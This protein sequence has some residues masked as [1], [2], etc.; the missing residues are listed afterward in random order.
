M[1]PREGHPKRE[2]SLVT[3]ALVELNPSFHEANADGLFMVLSGCRGVEVGERSRSYNGSTFGRWRVWFG[4]SRKDDAVKRLSRAFEGNTLD[5]RYLA[6][7]DCFNRG[8]YFEAHEVLEDLWLEDRSGQDGNFYKGLIQLA[9][10]FVH[11]QK[12]RTG[13]AK[14]LFRLA[15]SN[16]SVYPDRHH[17]VE[18]RKLTSRIQRWIDCIERG[19][20]M[21]FGPEA[22]Q[23]HSQS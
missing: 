12:G 16:L 4:M 2:S 22:L 18:T 11:V 17:A 7:F 21:P 15:L 19:N 9:G 10:A 13:P 23:L 20:A 14:A 1:E 8:L 6:F 3:R 5:A